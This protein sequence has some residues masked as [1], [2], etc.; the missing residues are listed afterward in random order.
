MDKKA[1]NRIAVTYLIFFI[2]YRFLPDSIMAI[3]WQPTTEIHVHHYFYGVMMIMVVGFMRLVYP[4][5]AK[6]LLAIIYGFGLFFV[7]DQITMLF[8]FREDPAYEYLVS[9]IVAIIFLLLCV[10]NKIKKSP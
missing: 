4:D 5:L 1:F 6:N 9:T 3:H 10:I 2:V 8:K 7:L